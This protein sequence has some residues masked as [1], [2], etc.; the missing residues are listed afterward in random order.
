MEYLFGNSGFV[1]YSGLYA[2]FDEYG[3]NS[4]QFINNSTLKVITPSGPTNGAAVNITIWDELGNGYLLNAAYTYLPA[5]SDMDGDGIDNELDDCPNSAGNSTMDQIGCPDSDGD[6]YSDSGDVFPSDSSEWADSDGDGVGN[7]GDTFPTDYNE[8]QDSDGDGVGNNGDAFPNDANETTDSDGDG[9]GDNS[10]AF[11]NNSA[12]NFDFDGDGVG[13]NSDEFP[14]DANE[15]QDSDGDG[16]GD[17]GD[18]YPFL[19]N[20]NDSDG[21]SFFDLED[22]FPNDPTQWSDYD[23]DGH[24]DNPEGNDSDLFINNVTQWSDTDGDGFG[25]NW[26]NPE[27]NT[28]RLFVWPGQFV[29]GAEL[30]DH[31]PTQFGNSSADGFFGC[32]DD[33]KDGIANIYDEIDNSQNETVDLDTDFD[34]I[35][36]SEDLCPDS[37]AGAF[38]DASGCLVDSDGDG[39]DDLQDKCPNTNLGAIINVEGCE[40]VEEKEEEPK[41]YTESLFAGDSET[42][43]KTAG[44]G[45]III[46]VL[47]FMQTNFVAAMLPDAVRWLQFMKKKSKLSKEEEQ[48]L[49]YLQSIVQAYYYDYETISEELQQLKSELTAR[50]TNNE[51]KKETREKINVLIRD[52]LEM[53]ATEM[54][55]IAHDDTYFGL[56]GT[57]DIKSRNELLEEDLAMRTDNLSLFNEAEPTV[58]QTVGV[59]SVPNKSLVGE[60]NPTDNH[61]YLEYPS[62][63]GSWYLRNPSTSEWDKWE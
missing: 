21:D 18:E 57:I 3:N 63:S 7:N 22:D 62:G 53:D 6:G 55:R 17:N 47:G 43:L 23:G 2:Q 33:D 12:E 19:N 56:A 61:E 20:F 9:V 59:S 44:Y 15:T 46:A 38:V 25:D 58:S 35:L 60:I 36:D 37:E 52:L 40:V 51:I 32:P 27:W 48:E 45:A 50:F 49:L 26:G 34:G 24:G 4:I 14:D 30:A 1:Q 10:D 31:C 54:N 5:S 42:I 8:T 28:T 39:I 13:D 41:S 16:I 11:P 29:E